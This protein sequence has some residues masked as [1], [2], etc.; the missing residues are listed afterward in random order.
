MDLN[1]VRLELEIVI[2]DQSL[3]VTKEATED[4]VHV[5]MVAMAV[6]LQVVDQQA[7]ME[8]DLRVA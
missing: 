3:E 7:V 2:L 1:R 5:T 6:D 4:L 8:V